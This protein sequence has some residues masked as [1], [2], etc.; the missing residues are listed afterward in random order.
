[1]LRLQTLALLLAFAPLA[2]GSALSGQSLVA[3]YQTLLDPPLRQQAVVEQAAFSWD[4]LNFKLTSGMLSLGGPAGHGAT[5]AVFLGRGEL[6]VLPPNPIAT[7]QMQFLLDRSSL[8][9]PFTEAIFRFASGAQF[10]QVVGARVSFHPAQP[11][12]VADQELSK[13]AELVSRRGLM[14]VARQML[15]LDAARPVPSPGWFLA[16]LKTSSG[17]VL[18]QYDPL[19]AEAVKVHAFRQR[20]AYGASV[21]DDVWA[22]FPGEAN[23]AAPP[24]TVAPLPAPD[25]LDQY[26]LNVTI[27]SNLD[28]QVAARW[29]VAAVKGGRGLLL[30][31][32]PN[33]RVNAAHL[34]RGAPVEYVQPPD[35]GRNPDPFYMGSWIYL[36]L[37]QALA[38]GQSVQLA[39][40]YRG[41]YIITKVG[42]GNFFVQSSGWYPSNTFGPPFQRASYQMQFANPA[43]YQLVA[44]GVRQSEHTAN[45]QEVS[46]WTTPVPLTVA[47]FAFGAYREL[48]K[49][50]QLPGGQTDTVNV[51]TNKNPDDLF[52]SINHANELGGFSTSQDSGGAGGMPSGAAGLE[53]QPGPPMPIGTLNTTHLAP[54]ALAQVGAALQFMTSLYGPYPYQSL[55]VVPIPYPY[56]QG[57][58]GLL[59]LS[60]LS[61]L[62]S[63]QQDALGLG[64]SAMNQLSDTFRAHETSHQW[65]GHRVGWASYHD[66]WLS[67]GLANGSALLF[68]MAADGEHAGLQTLQQWKTQLQAKS[69]FGHR[70]GLDGAL[71]L[72]SRLSSSADP[73]G[74]QIITYDKGGYVLYMLWEMMLDTRSKQPDAAFVAMMHDF[75][76]TYANRNAST[77]DF[78]RIVEKHMTPDMDIEG[79][80]SM[81]WFFQEYVYRTGIPQLSFRASWAP[82]SGHTKLTMTVENPGNW[83]G[84]LPVT[85]WVGK[86]SLRGQLKIT[87]PQETIP[88]ELGFTPTRVVANQNLG[89]LVD[90]KQ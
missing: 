9:L 59:Y 2:L 67:E 66:Q 29:Q 54:T 26:N 73:Q 65:W 71:W 70:H 81:N 25:R 80:H 77:A 90:V 85:I 87:Q 5:T 60:D 50:V 15:A 45:G 69:I 82:D 72:G 74:Y 39:M 41:Q 3:Q 57:W 21:F 47:G 6:D 16:A 58:P 75:T 68:Q 10:Q 13:R 14:S 56:G 64:L 8:A 40:D 61:F 55:S 17:W 88:I 42:T 76:S 84:L 51:L 43:K 31:L 32:D 37:P 48:S 23:A 1:M 30:Q 63:T 36:R 7:Q 52:A 11:G 27:P 49:P 28:M 83:Q 18:A 34:A 4:A 78:Q 79:D 24:G 86:K 12:T 44:T 35:P 22:H 62:D 20:P 19:D 33:L 38:P 89:M 53:S 46:L